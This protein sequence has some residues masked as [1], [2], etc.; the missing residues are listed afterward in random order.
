MNR[1]R[2]LGRRSWLLEDHKRLVEAIKLRSVPVYLETKVLVALRSGV[3]EHV[4]NETFIGKP[5][6]EFGEEAAPAVG[7]R[8]RMCH[9]DVDAA[10]Q[11]KGLSLIP[12]CETLTHLTRSCR[13]DNHRI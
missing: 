6:D 3:V 5:L 7:V 13:V 9:D 10:G 12:C 4:R 2:T 8:I 11:S 1:S